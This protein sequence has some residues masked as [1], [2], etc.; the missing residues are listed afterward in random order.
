MP[1]RLNLLFLR[2]RSTFSFEVRNSLIFKGKQ[3]GFCYK[4]EEDFCFGIYKATWEEVS[5]LQFHLGV[6]CLIWHCFPW[7]TTFLPTIS[8]YKYLYFHLRFEL[9]T[10]LDI[11]G[12]PSVLATSTELADLVRFHVL[13]LYS[14][15]LCT[16][17]Q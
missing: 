5:K 7:T 16:G 13:M 9:R 15:N 3:R 17:L 10:L 14:C 11:N 12:L 1:F 4:S 8:K 2:Q 6:D